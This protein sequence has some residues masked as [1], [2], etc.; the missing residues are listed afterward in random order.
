MSFPIPIPQEP[1]PH[2]PALLRPEITTAPSMGIVVYPGG[3]EIEPGLAPPAFA[4]ASADIPNPESIAPAKEPAQEVGSLALKETLS[5]NTTEPNSKPEP[6]AA[7]YKIR[8]TEGYT[9]LASNTHPDAELAEQIAQKFSEG[10]PRDWS[11]FDNNTGSSK[12]L[13][14]DPDHPTVFVKIRDNIPELRE[15]VGEL[16]HPSPGPG[17]RD[18]FTNVRAKMSV[19]SEM[20]VAPRITE[21]LGTDEAQEIARRADFESVSLVPPLAAVIDAK[22][23]E[24]A[25]A[26]AWQPGESIAKTIRQVAEGRMVRLEGWGDRFQKLIALSEEL[27]TYLGSQGIRARDLGP[28]SLIISTDAAGKK[29]LHIIDVERST[30][31]TA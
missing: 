2:Q 18:Y 7:P 24:K 1:A 16:S 23:G 22:T 10:I 14:N 28:H 30:L 27:V 3:L 8:R 20:R 5:V 19:A 21:A 6:S 9:V 26:Y 11:K 29:H 25:T 13:V 4:G 31:D 17:L 12:Y 15:H